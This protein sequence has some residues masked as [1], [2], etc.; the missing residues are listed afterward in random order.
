MIGG[1]N[2]SGNYGYQTGTNNPARDRG[3]TVSAPAS[4]P[5]KPADAV[6]RDLSAGLQESASQ[7]VGGG[8]QPERRIEARRAA[9]DARLERFRADDVP[10]PTA[11]ALSTFATVASAG[12]ESSGEGVLAGIDILV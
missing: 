1:I 9:E 10:L 6:R 3:D 5:E 4:S 11:K 7:R 12:Q 2:P 8:E